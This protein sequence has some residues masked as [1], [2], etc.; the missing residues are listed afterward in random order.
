[1]QKFSSLTLR[2]ANPCGKFRTGKLATFLPQHMFGTTKYSPMLS[3]DDLPKF[4][5]N[6]AALE[7]IF[8]SKKVSGRPLFVKDMGI[9]ERQADRWYRNIPRARPYYAIKCNPDKKIIRTLKSQQA[10]FDCATAWEIK[11]ALDEG[12]LPE[13]IIF[14]NPIK[15]IEDLQYA[16][17]VGV[18]KMTF[19]NLDEIIKVRTHHRKAELILRLLPDDSGSLMRFGSKFG[20]PEES[21]PALLEFCKAMDMKVLGVSFHIGS[22]CF[23]P[24]KYE[25]AIKLS[26]WAF[27]EAERIGLP[28]LSM[29]DLGGGFPGNPV[30]NT[31]NED[32]TPSFEVF[33]E[34]IR[35][36]LDKHFPASEHLGLQ[37]VAEPG[38]YFATACGTLFTE[39]Q[40]KRALPKAE[41]GSRNFLYYITDGVYGSFNCIMFDHAK[42]IPQPV[43]ELFPRESPRRLARTAN[44]ESE[45]GTF[46]Q[47]QYAFSTAAA[48][49]VASKGTF[50]GPTCDSM[51]VICKDHPIPELQV[52]DWLA[53]SR[54]GAYTTAAATRFNGCHLADLQYVYSKAS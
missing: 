31:N 9:V 19:D 1:M 13:D 20:A 21:V 54:M 15:S 49:P 30:P 33:S 42:P 26:K 7:S 40:G 22:G 46:A 2:N 35:T 17:E 47:Q 51:D 32:G 10:G 6:I 8:S 34:V 37:I 28:K 50:F 36:S 38:R 43:A 44:F 4:S 52:G 48:V 53:F 45:A 16:K 41:D 5:T 11:A 39:V 25:E 29:L 18:T 14:A 27:E 24:N 12:V 23:D 3:K